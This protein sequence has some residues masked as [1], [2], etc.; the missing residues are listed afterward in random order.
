MIVKAS[1]DNSVFP[2]GENGIIPITGKYILP[3]G[4]DPSDAVFTTYGATNNLSNIIIDKDQITFTSSYDSSLD[5]ANPFYGS[6]K[7]RIFY[8]GL[9]DSGEIIILFKNRCENI[10]IPNDKYCDPCTGDLL[11][12]TVDISVNQAGDS[13][14]VDIQIS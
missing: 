14:T 3:N 1:D 13:N 4:V 7:Y 6:F 8:N 10:S 12:K 2:C 5:G 9:A 11:D